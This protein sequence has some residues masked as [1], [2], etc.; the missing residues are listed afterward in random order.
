LRV[1]PPQATT[2]HDG[3]FGP[4]ASTCHVTVDWKRVKTGVGCRPRRRPG[5]GALGTA[6]PWPCLAAGAR[7]D[8]QPT[9]RS[10]P[11]RLRAGLL[12]LACWRCGWCWP[13][14]LRG[15][16]ARGTRRK[17]RPPEDRLPLTGK[18]TKTRCESCHVNGVF[19]G[20]PRDCASRATC[21]QHAAVARGNVVM[22]AA[23]RCPPRPVLRLLPRHAVLHRGTL[24]PRRASPPAPARAATTAA[25]ARASR[26]VTSSPRASCDTCHR[27]NGMVAGHRLRPCRRRCRAPARP[28]TTA[29]APAASPR[30]TCRPMPDSPATT[31][32]G[33]SRHGDPRHGPTPRWPWPASARPA[34]R[35]AIRRPTGARPTIFPMPRWRRPHR[36]TATPATEADIPPGPTAAF[37]PVSR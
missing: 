31:A 17:L 21:R 18:H 19:K 25:S 35:G 13:P 24:Q 1:L 9:P 22:P 2:S 11:W 33:R 4:A 15:P 29:A 30:A 16:G 20:T 27:S 7:Q 5:C 36:P 26:P 14:V 23:A 12:R 10:C 37:M 6:S 28:A 32:T 34:T 3:A 8:E